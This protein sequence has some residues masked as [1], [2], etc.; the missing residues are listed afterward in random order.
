MLME[1]VWLEISKYGKK[2][3]EKGFVCG[4][5]GNISVRFSNFMYITRKGASLEDVTFKDVVYVPLDHDEKIEDHASTETSVH[6]EIYFKTDFK[7]IIHSHAPYAIAVSYFFNEIEPLE[8]EAAMSM[9]IV[10]VIEGKSGTKE[11]GERIVGNMGLCKAVIV[12]GHGVFAAGSS[13]EEA[14]RVTCAIERNCRQKYLAEILRSLG[15]KFI[16][17]KEV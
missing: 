1:S 11:L 10:K 12:R 6:K 15:F 7:A 8:I 5:G 13:L 16:K 3:T 9:G 17:P 4:H 14:Y 2:L